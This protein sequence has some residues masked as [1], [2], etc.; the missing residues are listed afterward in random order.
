MEIKPTYNKVVVKIDP[1]IDKS[2]GGIYIPH[3]AKAER[4]SQI[5]NIVATGPG[6]ITE[7]G[8][9][10]PCCVSVGDRVMV[11]AY[12]GVPIQIAEEIYTVLPDVDI[13]CVLP[14][15]Y[16]KAAENKTE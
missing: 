13:I 6:R 16:A 1:E 11:T 14:D 12:A 2:K 8:T 3:L 9:C 7:N 15:D 4:R 10:I 5:G